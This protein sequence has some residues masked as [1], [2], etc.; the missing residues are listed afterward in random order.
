MQRS[1]TRTEGS[2]INLGRLLET[3]FA[4]CSPRSVQFKGRINGRKVP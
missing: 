1:N 3:E 2:G 4:V